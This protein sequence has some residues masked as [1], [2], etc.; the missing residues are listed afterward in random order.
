[1]RL[2]RESCPT[3]GGWSAHFTARILYLFLGPLQFIPYIR[4]RFIKFHRFSGKLYIIGS[5]TSAITVFILLATTY[6]LPGAIPSLG[7]LAIIWIFTTLM[8]YHTASVK[9]KCKASQ[10]I[11]DSELCLRFAFVFI[12]LL[13]EINYLTGKLQFH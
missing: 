11:Y 6:S 7:F 9:S 10:T 2:E 12:R 4:N 5:L 13:P 8:A 3:N 1:M